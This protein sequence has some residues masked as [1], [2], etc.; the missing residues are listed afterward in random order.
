M[1]NKLVLFIIIK[2]YNYIPSNIIVNF[3]TGCMEFQ[4]KPKKNLLILFVRYPVHV[5]S[6]IN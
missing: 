5:K 2:N 6:L 3:V 1:D 4:D